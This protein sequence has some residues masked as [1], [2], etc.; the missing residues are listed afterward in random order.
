MYREFRATLRN[1]KDHEWNPA[2]ETSGFNDTQSPDWI[3]LHFK[4]GKER[5]G[6]SGGSF[7]SF[8]HLF[9]KY[10]AHQV[11]RITTLWYR[12]SQ[13]RMSWA[14]CGY[15]NMLRRHE[16]INP[17][18][19]SSRSARERIASFC[20]QRCNWRYIRILARLVL[21]DW[22]TSS[23]SDP[24]PTPALYVIKPTVII[25]LMPGGVIILCGPISR[26]RCTMF[27]SDRTRTFPGYVRGY[28]LLSKQHK[29]HIG[30]NTKPSLCDINK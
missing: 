13:A 16:S 25:I 30:I 7:P 23:P 17:W 8:C 9:V 24:S 18:I 19:I 2:V 3:A 28:L 14:H 11:P 21:D 10:S 5:T 12:I 20:S 27:C 26:P 6:I 29:A 22:F 1:E 15:N 4:G